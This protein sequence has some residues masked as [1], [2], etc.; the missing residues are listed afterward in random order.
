VTS[1]LKT[2]LWGIHDIRPVSSPRAPVRLLRAVRVPEHR[3][4]R[5]AESVPSLA[6]GLTWFRWVLFL[7]GSRGC[8]RAHP[9]SVAPKPLGEPEIPAEGSAGPYV[10]IN[11]TD[12]RSPFA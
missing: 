1:S 4:P 12:E 8:T 7:P 6:C 10:L 3:L 9:L 5:R 2:V 11:A